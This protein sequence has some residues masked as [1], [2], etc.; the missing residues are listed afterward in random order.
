MPETGP[1]S[2]SAAADV[3]EHAGLARRVR[4]VVAEVFEL[5]QLVAVELLRPVA[6]RARLA[7][8]AHVVDGAFDGPRVCAEGDVI[9]LPHAVELRAHVPLRP[10]PDVAVNAA[11]VR[12]RGDA[13]GVELRLHHGVAGLA[14][15][16]HRLGVL[17][18]AVAAEGAHEDED[19]DEADEAEEVAAASRVV[20]IQNRG[21]Q[22]DRV[23]RLARLEEHVRVLRRAAYDGA[24]GRERARPMSADEFGVDE[25]AHVLVGELL[26]LPDFVRGA[27]AVEDVEE[28]DARARGRGLRDER[29]VQNL[30]N[31]VG[32]QHRSARRACAHHV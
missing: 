7:R 18:G 9:E 8:G 4:L 1:A 5:A 21:R 19:E 31:A 25:R 11:D 16:L 28:G 14:A 12:V 17:V 6:V 22:I 20:Q 23:R 15:E 26:D 13:E 32:E 29:E 30:L 2:G 10:R 27:E 24:V 3:D